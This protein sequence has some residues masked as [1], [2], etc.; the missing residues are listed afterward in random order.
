VQSSG[1]GPTGSSG[2]QAGWTII[3]VNGYPHDVGPQFSHQP[4]ANPSTSPTQHPKIEPTPSPTDTLSIG[5]GV[6]RLSLTRERSHNARYSP[7]PG[8]AELT[9]ASFTSNLSSPV[10]PSRSSFSD[11]SGFA[12]SRRVSAQEERIKL[13]PLQPP[14]TTRASGQAPISLPPISS[15]ETSTQFN[16]SRAVLERLRASDTTDLS[17]PLPSS[18]EEHHRR[19]SSS[20]PSNAQQFGF[21]A[22]RSLD[23]SMGGETH[24]WPSERSRSQDSSRLSSL[25]HRRP[26]DSSSA[27]TSPSTSFL[28]STPDGVSPCD[29]S[30]VLPLTPH[31]SAPLPREP[32]ESFPSSMKERSG[33]HR[34]A[35]S[36]HTY[37]DAPGPGFGYDRDRPQSYGRRGGADAFPLPPY[38][39]EISPTFHEPARLWEPYGVNHASSR[40]VR[41]W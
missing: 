17:K 19:R 15:W 24:H 5:G 39:T 35:I 4:F 37:T 29:P 18:P 9:N 10:R 31:T 21:E 23:T 8:A 33:N 26:S 6:G 1:I 25:A 22:P 2:P 30:P 7:Y 36:S 34:T 28:L 27:V 11:A 3:S 38:K 14:A 16:D 13:P 32:H 12:S 40:P 41:P 20:A